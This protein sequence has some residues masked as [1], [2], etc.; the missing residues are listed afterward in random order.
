MRTEVT[1]VTDDDIEVRTEVEVRDDDIDTHVTS[2]G[3]KKFFM[4]YWNI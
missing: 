1:G 2:Q 4:G 3:R